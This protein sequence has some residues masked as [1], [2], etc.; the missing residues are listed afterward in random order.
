MLSKKKKIILLFLIILLCVVSLPAEE[1]ENESEEENIV[2]LE[3]KKKPGVLVAPILFYLP[4]TRLAF[5]AAGNF[6]FRLGKSDSSDRPSSISPVFIYT[7]N[8]QFKSLIDIDMYFKK[9]KYHL[10]AFLE[11]QKYPDKFFGIGSSVPEE[12]EEDFTPHI[13]WFEFTLMKKIKKHLDIGLQY[14]LYK[15]NMIEYEEGGLLAR[16]DIPGSAGSLLSGIIFRAELDSRDNIFS[17]ERG[18]FFKFSAGFYNKI[19]GSDF[20]YQD[21]R[22]DL[23]KYFPLFSNHVF[24]VRTIVETQ[25][26][27]VPFHR[28]ARMGGQYI[29]RGYFEGRYRD[30]NLAVLEAEYRLPLFWRFGVVG[31]AGAADVAHRFRD[32]RFDN[33]KYSYGFGLRY[34]FNKKEKMHIRF[35]IG[36]GKG[37]SGVYFSVFQAF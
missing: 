7:Q 4:E 27:T 9:G 13:F 32:F 26:G 28:L 33:L 29:M 22:L 11:F 14:D 12:Q 6:V 2:N 17:P 20:T 36:F 18:M 25:T 19:I 24:A 16:G 3:K 31:F 1:K 37:T 34:L 30:R 21:Y 15:L 5:G 10:M 8:K 23:R 35:D